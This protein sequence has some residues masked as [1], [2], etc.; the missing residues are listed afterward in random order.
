M[1]Y[2]YHRRKVVWDAIAELIRSGWTANT[3]C[4]RIQ[5]VYGWNLSVTAKYHQPHAMGSS[6]WW[7]PNFENR[8][9]QFSVFV[10]DY[11]MV[12]V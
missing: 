8:Q 9:Y 12:S 5:E 1:I 6:K 10:L 7:A 2:N 4:D 3:A 11:I